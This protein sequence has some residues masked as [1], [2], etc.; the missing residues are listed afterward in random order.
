MGQRDRPRLLIVGCSTRAAAWSAVRAGFQPVCADQ[1]ADADLQQIAEVLPVDDYPGTLPAAVA[2]V[3]CHAWMYVGALENRPDLIAEMSASAS[4]TGPLLS[5]AP[6]ALSLCRDPL[7]LQACATE[8]GLEHT[9]TRL[10][11]P[12]YETQRAKSDGWLLKPRLSG[13]GLGVQV[14]QSDVG[15]RSSP[16]NPVV[17]Q[18]FIPGTP[19]A[20]LGL[21]TSA[22]IE[23]LGWTV[24]WRAEPAASPPEPFAYCGSFGPVEVPSLLTA[25]VT[26]AAWRLWRDAGLLGPFGIDV[27]LGHNGVH[28]IE[29][30]PR[31]TASAELWELSRQQSIFSR[32]SELE[33]RL[34][35]ISGSAPRPEI[36]ASRGSRKIGKLI[37]YARRE[38]QA[39][40]L[41]RFLRPRSPWS[42]PW[43][44]DI[45]KT[46][47]VIPAGAPLCTLFAT[48]Q[49]ERETLDVLRRRAERVRSWFGDVAG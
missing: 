47:T 30:N 19:A 37:L 4:R 46:G 20:F 6:E 27:V 8:A 5:M 25:C 26:A 35:A 1:F 15:T 16:E 45:P 12:P 39:P 49:A 7:R 32:W 24:A 44:A 28:L 21:A 42:V 40:D 10:S 14:W 17:W 9:E 3:D 22:G 2:D 38:V 36:Q 11:P 18:R 31:Y 33:P 34:A 23:C 41:S 29:C 13:G 48:G 43:V